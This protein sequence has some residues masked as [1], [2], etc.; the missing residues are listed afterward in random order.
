[1]SNRQLNSVAF[2]MILIWATNTPDSFLCWQWYQTDKTKVMFNKFNAENLFR[3]DSKCQFHT[4]TC[5][6]ETSEQIHLVE[7]PFIPDW[8]ETWHTR[9]EISIETHF[10][11]HQCKTW[12]PLQ[13]FRIKKT[14]QSD[15]HWANHLEVG[16]QNKKIKNTQ[17]KCDPVPM[18][19]LIFRSV[20][21]SMIASKTT[22]ASTPSLDLT[23]SAHI[24]GQ[25]KG[26]QKRIQ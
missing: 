13:I 8:Q 3:V 10:T 18:A 23:F 2:H 12:L 7:F 4:D 1:M 21:A 16:T 20:L 17:Q 19:F 11:S 15:L 5:K 22:P 25:Q 24:W 9:E 26:K 6:L 14:C